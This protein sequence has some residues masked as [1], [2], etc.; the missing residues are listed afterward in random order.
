[1]PVQRPIMHAA[2]RGIGMTLAEMEQLIQAA[3]NA[4]A[5]DD[6]ILG[7]QSPVSLKSFS[8]Y[9]PVK[10]ATFKW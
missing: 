4:G 7:I 3:R 5:P 6:A 8:L 2:D 10:E 9:A 1:M